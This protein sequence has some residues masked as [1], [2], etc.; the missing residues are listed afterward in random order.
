MSERL[1]K[2]QRAHLRRKLAAV[3][4]TGDAKLISHVEAQVKATR[5]EAQQQKI[6]VNPPSIDQRYLQVIEKTLNEQ[7]DTPERLAGLGVERIWLRFKLKITDS[8]VRRSE[9][10]EFLD[11]IETG[12]PRGYQWLHETVDYKPDSGIPI[13]RLA[14]IRD[15]VLM[16]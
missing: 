14:Q 6:R 13:N 4:E 8:D 16:K 11:S 9:L 7:N 15:R 10:T 5:L 2:G 3:R 1:S 12:N